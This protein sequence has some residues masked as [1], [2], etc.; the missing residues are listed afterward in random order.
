MKTTF[1]KNILLLLGMVSLFACSD[2]DNITLKNGDIT[3]PNFDIEFQSSY[4]LDKEEADDVWENVTWS[5]IKYSQDVPTGYHIQVSGTEDFATFGDVKTVLADTASNVLVKELNNAATEFVA[6]GTTGDIYL[7]IVGGLV[8]ANGQIKA[9]SSWM[10]TDEVVKFVLTT[11]EDVPG[12]IFKVGSESDWDAGNDQAFQLY[13]LERNIFIGNF[14]MENGEEFKFLSEA[15]NWDTQLNGASFNAMG[16]EFSG[17]DNITFSGESGNYQVVVDRN[18]GTLML[19]DEVHAM[20]KVGSQNGWNDLGSPEYFE[21]PLFHLY[22]TVYK[23]A[24]DM[25]A[26]E[27][28]KFIETPGSWNGEISGGALPNKSSDFEGD[29]NIKFIGT[30]GSYEMILDIDKGELSVQ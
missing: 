14:H 30:E 29:G 22:G 6:A 10:A 23:G 28:F 13:E 3:A 5:P 12:F 4:V 27:E 16:P 2:D 26:D 8:D 9:D 15:G 17:S 11:Y 1:L 20:Y 7:R 18:A 24:V 25:V 19:G 21:I